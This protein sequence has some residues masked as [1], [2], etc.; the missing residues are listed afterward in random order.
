MTGN[1]AIIVAQATTEQGADAVQQGVLVPDSGATGEHTVATTE[2]EGGEHSVGF[3]PFKPE[4]FASQIL[5]M[6]I[7]FAALYLIISR[8]AVPQ[9]LHGSPARP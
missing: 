1:D 6:A 3:P 2:A 9:T 5:W 4:T 8:M 7:C